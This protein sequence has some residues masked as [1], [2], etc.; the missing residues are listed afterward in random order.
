MP[1]VK[2][3]V[4]PQ[5]LVLNDK[6]LVEGVSNHDG[7]EKVLL[8]A[9][10]NGVG[11]YTFDQASLDSH[12]AEHLSISAA[13]I[14]SA[15]DPF[16]GR[17]PF[18]EVYRRSQ[19]FLS[20]RI[21]N[22]TGL[23][24]ANEPVGIHVEFE[25]GEVIS[26]DYLNVLDQNGSA[27]AF[28]WEGS[29][30]WKTET[31]MS[32]WDWVRDTS[33]PTYSSATVFTVPGDKTDLYFVG[34]RVQASCTAGLVTGAVSAVS[35]ATGTT[36]VTLAMDTTVAA[37]GVPNSAMALD[38]GLRSVSVA[39]S[40]R[41]GTIWVICPSLG[42][43]QSLLYQIKINDAA[44]NNAF[45]PALTYTAGSTSQFTPASV[46][47]ITYSFESSQA[48]M[49]RRMYDNR[50]SAADYFSGVNGVY[51][52]N[53]I[54]GTQNMSYTGAQVTGVASGIRNAQAYGNGVV[55][56][57]WQTQFQW[58][59]ETSMWTRVRYRIW[60]NNRVD[61][62]TYSWTTAAL[63]SS[64]RNLVTIATCSSTGATNTQ[65]AT[66]AYVENAYTSPT[67]QI[68]LAGLFNQMQSEAGTT[69]FSAYYSQPG[70]WQTLG[71]QGTVGPAQY[72]YWSTK[73]R[74]SAAYASGDVANEFLRLRNPLYSRANRA[75]KP[76]L[77]ARFAQLAASLIG[78]Y[79]DW[80]PTQNEN[81]WKG[82]LALAVLTDG[83]LHGRNRYSEAL[84]YFNSW[85]SSYSLSG[86]ASDFYTVWNNSTVGIE[87]TGRNMQVAI[88]L[89]NSPYSNAIDREFLAGVI[90]GYA[91]FIVRV[92]GVS[93]GAGQVPIRQN[94]SDNFNG[95]SS[96][97]R[98]LAESLLLSPGNTTRSACLA[99]IVARFQSGFEFK[100]WLAYSMTD[101]GVLKNGISVYSGHYYAF[102][103]AEYFDARLI[104]PSVVPD[105][106]VT[107][108][109][110]SLWLTNALGQINER[111]AN[112]DPD[113]RG[114]ANSALY[115]ASAL[116]L[117][118]TVYDSDI[119]AAIGILSHL[120]SKAIPGGMF[121]NP[122]DGWS[123][124]TTVS[125]AAM[126]VRMLCSAVSVLQ[127]I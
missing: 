21:T 35:Y 93:G 80:Y 31:D 108:R 46:G 29:F 72:S 61:V 85:L 117:A 89:Y 37:T 96:G 87:Y 65:N 116:L 40:L 97:I 11:G 81:N 122:V 88:H 101:P 30:D 13:S 112:N 55:F 9:N 66:S 102:A 12:S 73:F 25:R 60:A 6:G 71:W 79:A 69:G 95:E 76:E 98:A 127:T 75:A 5:Q 82:C 3:P 124:P 56:R 15:A 74:I 38:S 27:L 18:A 106:G 54:A 48:Y 107:F 62:D 120:Q 52:M 49:L 8:G 41:A 53:T 51:V 33:T 119:S 57:E 24:Y 110:A 47:N 99:R 90:H 22:P 86:S 114:V 20:A 78:A 104:N 113:R 7:S 2:F 64:A 67:K 39:G 4:A 94:T 42:A 103:V 83:Y 1:K 44:Q 50:Y 68:L 14:T 59:N 92:E 23:A 32:T 100:N 36:T 26:P 28:Q 19:S 126:D 84:A 111:L 17:V 34:R 105:L 45:T 118:P 16:G 63:T 77:K 125:Q 58:V 121:Q 91:D 10:L 43:T 70:V 123:A 115:W 109:P